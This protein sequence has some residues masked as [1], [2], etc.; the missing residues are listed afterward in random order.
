MS[1]KC[2]GNVVYNFVSSAVHFAVKSVINFAGS[3][4]LITAVTEA[5]LVSEMTIDEHRSSSS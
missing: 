1:E 2:S 4:M 5:Y 3:K